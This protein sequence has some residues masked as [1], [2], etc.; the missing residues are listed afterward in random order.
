LSY[1]ITSG[2]LA[3]SD[4]F[5]G[6]LSRDAGE[7]VGSYPITQGDLALSSN[8]DLSYVGADL[9]ISLRAVTVTADGKSKIYGDADPALTYQFSPSLVSGDSFNGLLTRAVGENLGLYAIQQGSLALSS[10]YDLNYVGANLSINELPLQAEVA[11]T[12]ITCN[13]ANNGTITISNPSGGEGSYQYRL[14]SGTWQ[15]SGS[16][17]GLGP[18][19]YSVQMRD[20]AHPGFIKLLCTK[21]ISQPAV[22]SAIITSDKPVLYFGFTGDQTANITATPIGGTAPY[23]I[24]IAMKNAAIASSLRGDGKLICD[25]VNAAGDE[26]WTP[27]A[28][29]K[30]SLSTGIT[31]PTDGSVASSTSN[32]IGSINSSGANIAIPYSVNVKLLADARFVAKITDANGCTYETSWV[33]AARVDAEDVRCFAGN[34][35]VQKITICHKTGSSKNPCVAICVD[36]SA[37]AEHLAHGDFLGKCTSNCSP[38]TSNSRDEIPFNVIAYPNP[39][40]NQF[41]FDIESESSDTIN[42][43]V[44]DIAGRLIKQLDNIKESSVTFGENLPRGVY[45]AIVQQ[46]NNQKTVRIIKE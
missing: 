8:Y 41:T 23:T 11:K 12:D 30:A 40:N 18:N 38:A 16:F 24:K 46:G 28:N 25:Y 27:G 1:Q 45:I 29:T 39:S 7:D 22:L 42:I 21:S 36:Q 26:V 2:S 13:G 14:N 17:V 5:S 15:V 20:V 31:C 19:T 35:G 10:N 43:N 9:D 4:A 37:V 34:S 32:P 3:Y 6:G 44:F 33:D